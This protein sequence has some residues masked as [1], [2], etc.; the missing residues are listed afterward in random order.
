M[1]EDFLHYIWKFQKFNKK[2]LQ[3]T[4]G[5][6]LKIIASG[7]HNSDSG[8]DFFNA[9]LSLNGQVW[10]GNVEI[11]INASDWY[12]HHHEK[13]PAYDNVI[14]HVV[15][16]HDADIFRSDNSVIPTIVLKDIIN[17]NT[18]SSYHNLFSENNR[19][20]NCESDF[21]NIDSFILDNWLERLYFER[22]ESK[23]QLLIQ[24][25]ESLQNH[26][27]ALLFRMLCKNFGLK[28]NG[29]AFLSVARS[30][31]FSVVQKCS[32]HKLELEAL[33]L[34]QSGLL[35]GEKEDDYYNQL[36]NHYS[37]LKHKFGLHANVV[38][39]PKFFRLRPT[40]FP[41]IR[42]SQL[43]NL[44]ASQK[45]LFSEII[46]KTEPDQFY[47]LFDVC[48]TEYWDT[49]Y[50]FGTA[51]RVQKKSLNKKFIDLL[52][53]NT[54]IPLKF[55]YA[56]Y[57]GKNLNSELL[58]LARELNKE[59]NSIIKKF[60]GIGFNANSLFQSQ[61]LLQLKTQYCEKQRCLQCEIG[62]LILK[63]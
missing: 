35:C 61:A 57:V 58:E 48:A 32:R 5:G 20:I 25:L 49:H 14:M 1:K 18:L 50:N 12:A 60:E 51:S 59:D 7:D 10:A 34:G 52:L 43:S 45:A 56:R 44:Y 36:K 17:D 46:D 33:L 55:C 37:F 39:S 26:W 47:E 21:T 28:V 54:I 16:N 31:P 9:K 23:S 40:N 30:L 19:W 13:D 4:Q 2:D 53:V 6:I 24:E 42:L 29:D 15:W 22:L 11:H 27:E 63:G 8:P 3:T 38:I 62:N 41:T